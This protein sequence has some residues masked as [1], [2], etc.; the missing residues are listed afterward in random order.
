MPIFLKNFSSICTLHYY[1]Q[2]G[3]LHPP[4]TT[5]A[6]YRMYD[7]T[8]LK[9]LQSIM[10]FKELEFPLKDIKRI[11][12][13]PAF[14]QQEAL[15]QQIQ[16]LTMK[17]EHIENLIIFAKGMKTI[18]VNTMDLMGLFTEFGSMMDCKPEDENVQAQVRKLQQFITD[19][20]YTCT[21]EILAGLGQMYVAGGE[22]TDNIDSAGG[23]GTAEFAA[24]AIAFY[25]KKQ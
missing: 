15:E 13:S 21:D 24:R 1:D 7:N 9:R 6:G 2:I 17:K 19:N 25:C 18:G 16:L 14:D 20:Y 23:K 12:D 11:I 4:V 5:E 3:L 22:M 8:S 10:L